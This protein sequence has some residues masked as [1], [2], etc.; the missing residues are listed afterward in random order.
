M[1]NLVIA[2]ASGL[3]S[4]LLLGV[5]LSAVEAIIPALVV[6]VAAY[7]V[8]S[9]RTARRIEG[10]L[11]A[12]QKDLMAGRIEKAVQTIESARRFAPWQFFVDKAINSQ[13]GTIHFLREDFNKAMPLLE[14]GDPRHWVSRAMLA[15]CYFKKK[16]Y[17]KMD[18]EF[19][20]AARF[21]AKQGLLYSLWAWCHWKND[22]NDRALK[23]LARGDQAL[24]GKDERIK[25]NLLNLQNGKKMKMKGYAEQWYQFHLEKIPQP[26]PQFRHR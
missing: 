3:L 10:I 12:A 26:R 11:L 14:K 23:I 1:I 16:D 20:S 6:A 2:L 17:A 5:W 22:E 25:Q 21:S 18:Q 13:L 8:I 7:F 15:V 24:E 19:E 4:G 9:R